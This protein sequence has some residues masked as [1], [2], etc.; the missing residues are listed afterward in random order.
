MRKTVLSSIIS[1]LAL[2][3]ALGAQANDL[4]QFVKDTK[5]N[6]DF[7]YRVES[8]D[9]DDLTNKDSA[10][11]NTLRS[12][13]SVQTG[14]YQGL[15]LLVEADNTLHVTDDFNDTENNNTTYDTVVDPETTQLNQAYLQ[16][17]NFDTVLKVG[18]QRINLDNQRHVG[19]VAFRQDEATFDAISIT[20]QSITGTTI[21]AAVANNRNSI[22]NEN[23][24]EDVILLNVN[25]AINNDIKA[26]AFY[27]D[28][29]NLNGF[30]GADANTLGVRATGKVQDITFEAELARQDQEITD[31]TPLYYHLAAGTQVG[32]INATLGL[33]VL[34]S[35]GGNASFKTPLGTNH[36]FLGWSDT[37]LQPDNGNGLQ[38]LYANLVSKVAGVK[39]V[40]QIH[41]FSSDE[42]G[43]D[44][45]TELGFLAAKTINN[46]GVSLKLAQYNATAES[47]KV[48]TTKIWLT[49][50]A[51]F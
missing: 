17:N 16:Y 33:E 23:L 4:D 45:G 1:S 31:A 5:L 32:P 15:S 39:L 48:D 35:D 34:G 20:N 40:G 42:G 46:Y 19:G 44:Y 3:T 7:R 27:Y 38:D 28:V 50:S 13:L 12:R 49:G 2:S 29:K 6:A 26:A 21:F 10:L 30:D 8:V 11:A 51:K 22:K 37:F 9:Q 25:R 36:K 47:G 18:N 43:D 14:S 41:S 24:E